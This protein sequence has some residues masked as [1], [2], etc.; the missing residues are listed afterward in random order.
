MLFTPILEAML[1][2]V[3]VDIARYGGK[4]PPPPPSR[5]RVLR[6]SALAGIATV[7]MIFQSL[8]LGQIIRS[9]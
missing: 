3:R 6:A 1:L 5:P 4:P 2:F 9:Q 7:P 8:D